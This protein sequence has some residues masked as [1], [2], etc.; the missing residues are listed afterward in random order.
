MFN[1]SIYGCIY[2][3]LNLFVQAG[4]DIRLIFKW[5]LTD[6]NSEF[7]FSKTSCHT[8]VKEPSLPSYLPIAAR[9]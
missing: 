4:Y 1:I 9:R 7:S 2:I 6:L 3:Y 5:S 8:K